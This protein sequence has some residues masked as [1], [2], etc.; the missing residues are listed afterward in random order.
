MTTL[1]TEKQNH[2]SVGVLNVKA[3]V[4]TAPSASASIVNATQISNITSVNASNGGKLLAYA[5]TTLASTGT[6]AYAV[7]A[8]WPNYR[9]NVKPNS[10]SGTSSNPGPGAGLTTMTIVATPPVGPAG[11]PLTYSYSSLCVD[12]DGNLYAAV[13]A[14]S[15]SADVSKV[16]IQK[17]EAGTYNQLWISAFVPTTSLWIGGEF[18]AVLFSVALGLNNAL[19][20]AA[21]SGLYCLDTRTGEQ[22]WV[23]P[24][25]DQS[26]RLMCTLLVNS[27]G[28]VYWATQGQVFCVSS[29]G[30]TLW[31]SMMPSRIVGI[32]LDDDSGILY[33][34][35]TGMT[36]SEFV[37]CAFR[38]ILCNARTG[39]VLQT[40]H[41]NVLGL[42]SF[43]IGPPIVGNTYVY[44]NN[45]NCILAYTKSGSLA[46]STRIR[47]IERGAYN[48]RLDLLYITNVTDGSA[49]TPQ[50]LVIIALNG[51]TGRIEYKST[52]VMT[53]RILY[54]PIID[55]DNNV[56]VYE[57]N[58]AAVPTTHNLFVF[59]SQLELLTLYTG[60]V[61]SAQRHA[62]GRSLAL[63][64][65][66]QLL[67][68]DD[69]GIH[70]SN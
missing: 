18:R 39:V 58:E 53:T 21:S 63:N 35:T 70:V 61:F 67:V 51:S 7:G 30:V 32:S 33:V 15:Y 52:I 8:A 68:A 25:R 16:A 12:A 22:R 40:D 34:S 69:N 26:I 19:Y 46:W 65:A 28:D 1:A 3:L 13:T 42:T 43:A 11:Q 17:L 9:G 48:S 37:S 66:G 49:T 2:A 57:S 10:M 47:N 36:P 31:T 60:S 5:P 62:Y 64:S 45:F 20:F 23:N 54:Y 29:T 4:S 6:G 38:L 14:K 44:V 55:A 50:N 59:N 24:L 27:Q 56:Y 41:I